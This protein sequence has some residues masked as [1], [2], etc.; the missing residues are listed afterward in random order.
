ML[1]SR[2]S[3]SPPPHDRPKLVGL[4]LTS[5]RARALAVGGGHA[6]PVPLDPPSLTL[7]MLLSLENRTP[8]AGRAGFDLVRRMPHQVCAN[9][10]PD[11][12]HKKTWKAYR[13]SLTPEAALAV[14]FD[15]LR[16]PL[17]AET[18]NLAVALPIY[19]TPAQAKAVGELAGKAKLPV[20]GTAAAPLAIAAHRAA[21]LLAPAADPPPDRPDWVVP[22]RPAAGGPGSVVVIDADEHALSAAVVSVDR[23][24]VRVAASAVWPKRSARLWADRLIDAVSDRCVRV[25]RRDPRDS[26]D[27]EQ[28]LYEQ[29][30]RLLPQVRAG[31][32][33]ALTVRADRWYQDM[34][35]APAE[36]EAAAALLA[37]PAGEAVRELVNGAGLPLPPRAVWLTDTAADLPGL[38]AAVYQH[39]AEAT[40]VA[41]LPADAAAA[42]ATALLARWHAGQLPRTHLDG[43]IPLDPAA[44]PAKTSARGKP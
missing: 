25:C 15:K 42:A 37:K 34:T 20:K 10:L 43:V 5:T 41:V 9:F 16:G 40:A 38:A 36:L 26:A 30:V 2:K 11:L 24:E 31:Q 3:P 32:S 1:W 8:N 4:D 17:L 6:R 7:P 29:L 44:K 39:S 12:G 13:G 21:G 28:N 19:L 33:I 23:T 14:V 18:E 35:L 22:I 27:A